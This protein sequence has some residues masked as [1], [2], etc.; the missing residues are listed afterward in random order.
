MY[1]CQETM[2][3]PYQLNFT[4][5]FPLIFQSMPAKQK[6]E[7]MDIPFYILSEC[8]LLQDYST[9]SALLGYFVKYKT[10]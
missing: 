8:Y 6:A 3:A 1:L 2:G 4:Q 10:S 7:N 9:S 5:H